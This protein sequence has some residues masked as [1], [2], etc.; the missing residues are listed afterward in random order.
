MAKAKALELMQAELEHDSVME[1]FE[2]FLAR[3]NRL[4]QQGQERVIRE[5]VPRSLRRSRRAGVG[6]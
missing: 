4:P 5:V 1:A 6:R 2:L 3:F